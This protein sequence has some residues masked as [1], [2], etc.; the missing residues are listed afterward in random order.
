MNPNLRLRFVSILMTMA[1]LM[2]C[3]KDNLLVGQ[4]RSAGDVDRSSVSE[5]FQDGTCSIQDRT[6]RFGGHWTRLPDGRFKIDYTAL[7]TNVVLMGTLKDDELYLDE[8]NGSATWIRVGSEREKNEETFQEGQKYLRS[9]DF[10]SAIDRFKVA[11]DRGYPL[12]QNALAWVYA[13]ANSVEARDG[14]KAVEY[15]EKAAA[16][17]RNHIFLD[18]LAAARARNG[19]FSKAC[20]VQREALALLEKDNTITQDAKQAAMQ[21][22]QARLELYAQG[23]AYVEAETPPRG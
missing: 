23:K 11:A 15:A 17:V 1:F 12:A 9:G 13:T 21:R 16:A 4:W 6:L 18:T 10:K 20:E 8:G 19:E 22:Y 2:S 3:K 14:K 5:F 7:G